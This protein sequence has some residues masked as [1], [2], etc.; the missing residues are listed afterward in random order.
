MAKRKKAPEFKTIYSWASEYIDERRKGLLRRVQVYHPLTEDRRAAGNV[1]F[2]A[3]IN[4]RTYKGEVPTLGRDAD[5]P[6][7]QRGPHRLDDSQFIRVS[8][9]PNRKATGPFEIGTPS[10]I[11]PLINPPGTQ[12]LQ[13]GYATTNPTVV[14]D[15]FTNSGTPGEFYVLGPVTTENMTGERYPYRFNNPEA[16]SKDTR[17]SWKIS[18][19]F[20]NPTEP[21]TRYPKSGAF[22]IKKS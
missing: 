9:A 1:D 21:A 2:T 3:D 13:Q 12:D 10:G 5:D 16:Y 22:K 6:N 8:N 17:M 7:K 11:E 19:D 15:S 20:E 18:P 14:D 4:H